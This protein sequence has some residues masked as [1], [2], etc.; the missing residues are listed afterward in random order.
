M[1][2]RRLLT[3]LC[4]REVLHP[5]ALDG[6]GK[7]HKFTSAKSPDGAVFFDPQPRN[8]P[9]NRRRAAAKSLR[10]LV[11]NFSD[12]LERPQVL[13]GR[14]ISENRICVYI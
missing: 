8:P 9:S 12:G 11:E 4:G 7:L 5:K 6:V 1:K 13:A 14:E 10:S 2:N 3:G